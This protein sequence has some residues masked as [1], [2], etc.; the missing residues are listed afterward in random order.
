MSLPIAQLG[1]PVLRQVAAV[2]PMEMIAQP[3]FQAFVLEMMETVYKEKGAGLAAP[4]VFVSQRVFVGMIEPPMEEGETPALEVFINPTVTA[5]GTKR[6]RAW[7]G[8]LSFP[9]LLVLVPRFESVRIEYTNLTGALCVKD[10]DDFAARVVQHELDHLEGVL[11]I[12]RAE[13]PRNIIKASE[14]EAVRES[15]EGE[16]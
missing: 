2:V 4:Q 10:L 7:E 12:D 11:T 15:T 13:T 1:Q 3:E 9:E 8:C 6:V 16:E 5:V 14:I